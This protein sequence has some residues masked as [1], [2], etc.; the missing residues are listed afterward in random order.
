MSAL[1]RL[2]DSLAAWQTAGFGTTLCRELEA[3][4]PHRLPLQQG[5]AHSSCVSDRPIRAMLVDDAGADDAPGA[6]VG[7]FYTGIVAGCNCADDP[8]PVDEQNE[9]CVLRITID[10]DTAEAQVSLLPD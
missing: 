7:V 5:L 10:P 2:P 8:T 1:I 9:Y 3:L 6:R 4:G